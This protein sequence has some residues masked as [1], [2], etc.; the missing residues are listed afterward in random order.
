MERKRFTS[1]PAVTQM[2]STSRVESC[3][4][5]LVPPGDGGAVS[6]GEGDAAA[7]QA[8][9]GMVA[10]HQGQAHAR[11]VLEHQQHQG[12]TGEQ[13]QGLA[14]FH[15]GAELGAEADGAEEEE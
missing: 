7:E 3:L 15:Q 6:A 14:A 12:H 13:C 5:R 9:A 1:S 4:G 10:A 8:V 2:A 11:R